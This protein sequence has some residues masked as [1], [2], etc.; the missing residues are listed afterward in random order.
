MGLNGL[1]GVINRLR[2]SQCIALRRSL[3]LCRLPAMSSP[4]RIA[5]T[6]TTRARNTQPGDMPNAVNTRYLRSMPP[7]PASRGRNG[8]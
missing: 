1:N 6:P 3:S 5:V 2:D 7:S 4:H 8:H